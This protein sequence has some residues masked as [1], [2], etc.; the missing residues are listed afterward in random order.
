[1]DATCCTISRPSGGIRL[2]RPSCVA[3]T[4]TRRRSSASIPSPP[5][6]ESPR[7][8]SISAARA[9]GAARDH[10][11]DDPWDRSGASACCVRSPHAHARRSGHARDDEQRVGDGRWDPD[12][13]AHG[14]NGTIDVDRHRLTSFGAFID[15][16]F[17]G[18]DHL[19]VL[20]LGLEFQRHLEEPRRARIAGVEP[21]PNPGIA[22]PCARH[23]STMVAAAS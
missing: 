8:R 11:R 13:A 19:H 10:R 3:R 23:L 21:C 6:S 14:R 9:G 16:H 12:V 20:A 4:P 18:P 5:T 2:V 22:S 15:H 17:H 7:R 1:M